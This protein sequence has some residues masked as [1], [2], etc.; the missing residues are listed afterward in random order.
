[1]DIDNLRVEAVRDLDIG[2]LK[3]Y[4]KAIGITHD[5]S[6]EVMLA[7]LHK[8][9]VA[10][11]TFSA[12]ERSASERWLRDHGYRTGIDMASALKSVREQLR[13]S[14]RRRN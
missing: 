3:A 5:Q 8:A 13:M 9:R 2:K 7:G 10:T 12:A 11:P 6:D 1:M 4:C 14:R